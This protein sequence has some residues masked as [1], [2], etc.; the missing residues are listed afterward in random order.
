M[1]SYFYD[2]PLLD[3]PVKISYIYEYNSY[4]HFRGGIRV[5]NPNFSPIDGAILDLKKNDPKAIELFYSKLIDIFDSFD[6]LNNMYFSAIPSHTA[7]ANISSMHIIAKRLSDHYNKDDYSEVLQRYK[8]I[9]RLSDGG[10]RNIGVHISSIRI[11]PRFN[12]KSKV[13]FLL[14]DITTSGSS[15]A[16]G[17]QILKI[18][19]ASKVICLALS[20]KF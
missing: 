11:N 2:H 18:G 7:N 8:N 14:D 13:F 3:R 4:Y 6:D 9:P 5:K 20:H 16:A 12:V 1:Y 10:F 19:G 15:M 17:S